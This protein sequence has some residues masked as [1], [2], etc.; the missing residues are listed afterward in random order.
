MT[1]VGDAVGDAVGA[2]VVMAWRAVLGAS[3]H[4]KGDD[5]QNDE[6]ARDE[7]CAF[8][9]GLALGWAEIGEGR[10]GGMRGLSRLGR[11][12]HPRPA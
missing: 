9:G 2:L 5:E 1:S 6:E 11:S 3:E 12:P 7:M 4:L 8:W 10:R